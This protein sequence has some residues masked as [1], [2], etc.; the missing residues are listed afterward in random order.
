M[1]KDH[2]AASVASTVS[3]F[4]LGVRMVKPHPMLYVQIAMLNLDMRML[5]IEE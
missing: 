3:H 2:R 4:F 1:T 5:L